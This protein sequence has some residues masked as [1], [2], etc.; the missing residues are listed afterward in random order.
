MDGMVR[1]CDYNFSYVKGNE[2]HQLGTG[3]FFFYTT[4]SLLVIGC[5]VSSERSLV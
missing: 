2:N 1:A 5:H 3:F 4:E